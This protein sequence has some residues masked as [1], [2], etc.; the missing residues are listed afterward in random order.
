MSQDYK[1]YSVNQIAKISDKQNADRIVIYEKGLLKAGLVFTTNYFGGTT[2]ILH[3]GFYAL[4]VGWSSYTESGYKS[5]FLG[6]SSGHKYTSNDIKEWF[7]SQIKNLELSE[8]HCIQGTL[9]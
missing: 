5:N 9:F 2:N 7:D 3:V 1:T 6:E 4:S 8:Q